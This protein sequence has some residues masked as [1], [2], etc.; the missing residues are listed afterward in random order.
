MLFRSG[1]PFKESVIADFVK[2]KQIVFGG[3]L[4]FEFVETLKE[5]NIQYFDF[6]KE[7]KI[8]IFNA[9]ATAEGVIAE[10]II[11]KDT[12]LHDS[13]VLVLGFGRCAKVLCDK[14]RGLLANVTVCCRK[15]EDFAMA[16]ALGMQAITFPM[17]EAQVGK[18]EYIFNT[19]PSLVIDKKIAEKLNKEVL[20]MDIASGK[21]GIDFVSVKELGIEAYQILGIPG[22]YACRASANCLGEYVIEKVGK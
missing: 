21:G 22:K 12:N 8:A 13:Q 1:T 3:A 17:L 11:K 2:E 20:I 15:E 9:I 10:A 16:R 4:P 6:M 19:V 18:F 5:Q 14:L 7:N